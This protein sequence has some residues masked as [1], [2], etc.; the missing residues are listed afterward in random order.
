M[1]NIFDKFLNSMRLYDDEDLEEDA[2]YLDDEPEEEEEQPPARPER[3]ERPAKAERPERPEKQ[4]RAPKKTRQ[5]AP[6]EEEEPPRAARAPRR[7]NVTSMRPSASRVSTVMEVSMVKPTSMEDAR[8]I[9]DMLLSG[10]AVVI[11]MEGVQVDLA[12]RIIDFA[13][14]ACYSIEGN[15][16]KI[17]SYIFIVSPSSIELS[18]DFQNVL[19]SVGGSG[20]RLD[21]R[22]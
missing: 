18:G 21:D 1:A 8:D 6:E 10:R 12:Q 2:E 20:L 15:I 17:S 13:S 22:N 5:P 11:N 3:P 14:G 4:E 7:S 16:Q 9:C 19:S